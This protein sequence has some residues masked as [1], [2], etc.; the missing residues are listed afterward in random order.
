MH[1][2]VSLKKVFFITDSYITGFKKGLSGPPGQ[3]DFFAGQVT[4]Y[5]HLPTEQEISQAVC[6]LNHLPPFSLIR[7]F[8]KQNTRGNISMY[9][10]NFA[11][12][13]QVL[14]GSL[15]P[16]SLIRDFGKQNT[17][18]NISK[19]SLVLCVIDRS[20]QNPPITATSVTFRPSLRHVS[21]L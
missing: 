17:R 11:C 6:Q 18:G 3:E 9:V 8:G 4:L 7:D 13:E 16:F 1:S 2:W 19:I 21:R 14:V 20:D 10:S 12:P 15:P 5:C